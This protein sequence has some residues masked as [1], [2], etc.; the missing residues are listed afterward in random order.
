MRVRRL[1]CHHDLGAVLGGL[2]GDLLADAAAGSRDE[3]HPAG[4]LPERRRSSEV[5][6]GD[7]RQNRAV[8]GSTRAAQ[9]IPILSPTPRPCQ[10]IQSF[11]NF[12]RPCC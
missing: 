1:G 2:Q 11:Q 10:L 12:Q 4:Q 9:V 5:R 8:L 3:D 6:S 7:G